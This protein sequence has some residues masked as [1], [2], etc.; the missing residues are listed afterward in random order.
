M[1]GRCAG[2][3]IRCRQASERGEEI[4]YGNSSAGC[5]AS[6]CGGARLDLLAP[7]R[8]GRCSQVTTKGGA[9][10]RPYANSSRSLLDVGL[11]EPR[12]L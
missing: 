11:S 1:A 2:M 5:A 9:P 7:W 3:H 12:S 8:S 4:P 6:E 10:R